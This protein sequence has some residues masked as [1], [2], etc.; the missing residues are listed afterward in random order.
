MFSYLILRNKFNF[1]TLFFLTLVAS[2]IPFALILGA[3]IAEVLIFILSVFFLYFV[4]LKKINKNYLDNFT[5]FLFLFWFYLFIKS[6]L[7]YEPSYSIIR[8]FFYFRYIFFSVLVS[9]LIINYYNFKKFFLYFLTVTL[10]ILVVHAYGQHLF[11]VDLFY[12]DFKNFS[13]IQN[14]DLIMNIWKQPVDYR[15]SGLF[16][17]ESILGSFL[18]KVLPLYIALLFYYEK[19][20]FFYIFLALCALVLI[21]I[22]GERAAIAVSLIFIILLL[23]ATSFKFKYYLFIFYALVVSLLF[24]TNPNVKQRVY[25]STVDSIFEEKIN[26]VNNDGS[27][28]PNDNL[29]S[30]I[31][32]KINFFSQGHE[33]HMRAGLQIFNDNKLFGVGIKGFRYECGKDKYTL[34]NFYACTTHPHNTYIQLL[35]ETGIFGFLFVL[36][37]YIYLVFLA[38]KFIFYKKYRNIKYN[39]Y[40]VLVFSLIA[41]LFPFMPSG[42]FFNNWMSII[43]F[44]LLAFFMSEFKKINSN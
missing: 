9:Y 14:Y 40:K 32:K 20:S 18:I 39:Y 7:N 25:K 31:T 35:A 19:K 6:L 11:N 24:F 36:I 33:G 29:I 42:S 4:Y 22:S 27:I 26:K 37:F 15:I 13:I 10:T 5:K 41:N 23:V 21:I 1:S 38:L 43:Y 16:Y 12:L 17:S 34:N 2:L 8:S 3:F 28:A 44:L 30:K